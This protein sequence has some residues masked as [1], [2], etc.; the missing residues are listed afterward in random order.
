ML[1]W[2]LLGFRRGA[3]TLKVVLGRRTG[4]PWAQRLCH[5]CRL[6]FMMRGTLCLSALPCSVRGIGMLPYTVLLKHHAA[7]HVAAEHCGGGSLNRMP[8]VSLH[9]TQQA[10]CPRDKRGTFCYTTLHRGGIR[11]DL[12]PTAAARLHQSR[13][14]C[15]PAPADLRAVCHAR[16]VSFCSQLGL[17]AL[18]GPLRAPSHLVQHGMH[19]RVSRTLSIHPRTLDQSSKEG[20]SACKTALIPRWPGRCC[21]VPPNCCMWGSCKSAWLC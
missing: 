7:V 8:A 16:P 5:Q 1:Y 19:A 11:W 20:A 12:L 3:H 6:L 15:W 4:V 9:S 21:L 17:R 13:R 2:R 18:H 10:R 14:R